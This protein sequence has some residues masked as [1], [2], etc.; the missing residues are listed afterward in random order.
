MAGYLMNYHPIHYKATANFGCQSGSI[1]QLSQRVN[2]VYSHYIFI[3]INWM[4]QPEILEIYNPRAEPS[5]AVFKSNGVM[6]PSKSSG[7]ARM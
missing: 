6:L 1:Q 2:S 4:Q 5:F 3:K 7:D